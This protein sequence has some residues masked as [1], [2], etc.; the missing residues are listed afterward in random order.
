MLPSPPLSRPRLIST[1]TRDYPEALRRLSELQSNRHVTHLFDTPAP[2]GDRNAAA[3]PEMLTWLSR[4]GYSPRD[5]CQLRHIHV[6]GT[7]GKGSICAYAA[8]MLRKCGR[9]PVGTYTSPHLVSPR[10]RIAIDGEPVSQDVFAA[11]FFD[12]WERFSAAAQRDG[13]TAAQ[14][15]GPTTK[16]FY[17]RF[18]TILAW[19][20]FMTEG[21]GDAV[22]ECGIGGEYDATNIL[23]AEA[24]SA[25]VVGQLGIDHVAMLGGTVEEIAWHKAGI[26]K[27]GR[28]AF[29]RRLD[30][31]PGVM[32]V[33]RSR[34]EEKGATLVEVD[35]GAVEAWGGVK[36]ALEG[37]FQK[38]NQAL[39]VLAVKEHLGLDSTTLGDIPR[40]MVDGLAAA[41]LRGRGEVI[42]QDGMRW[43]LDGAHT[44]DSLEGVAAWLAR[45]L[46][47]EETVVLIFNQQERNA[48]ELLRTLLEAVRAI[49]NRPTVFSHAIFTTNDLS[50]AE[51]GE[52]RDLA[53]QKQ[54]AATMASLCPDTYKRTCNN[55]PDAVAEAKRAVAAKHGSE[56][57]L[58]T[59]SMHLAGGVLRTLEPEGLL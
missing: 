35:D 38:F 25:A 32:S 23:P 2:S 54:A 49:T 37:D 47:Q 12:V 17:F 21:V 11:A 7:K 52:V 41:K 50:K 58:V 13:M 39:A 29:T 46:G 57:V 10:E 26:L 19:H 28:K 45:D 20:I 34:A 42:E 1:T 40:E 33:L 30:G 51:E 4:A 8:S 27:P 16:P 15:D 6:A 18:L 53:V 59:G 48:S 22:M 55:I 31:Q 43:L 14:A 24:V 5:L 9:T 3:I 44:K 56:K 36:G